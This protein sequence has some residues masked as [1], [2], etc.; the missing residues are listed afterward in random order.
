MRTGGGGMGDSDRV[1]IRR[2]P[3]SPQDSLLYEALVI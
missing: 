1:I 2:V 3:L